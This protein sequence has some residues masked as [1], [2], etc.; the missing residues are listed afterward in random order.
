VC[1]L[2]ALISDVQTAGGEAIWLEVRADN[3][4][5]QALYIETGA[6]YSGSRKGYYSDGADAVLMSYA[7]G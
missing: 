3:R 4:A 5:A 7:F 2:K 1:L 6:V